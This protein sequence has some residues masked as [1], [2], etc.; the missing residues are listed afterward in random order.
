ML[1]AVM[2]DFWENRI[3]R[4]YEG[5]LVCIDRPTESLME[6]LENTN[7]WSLAFTALQ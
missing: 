3:S 7:L 4:L 6:I 1:A 5:V 2:W